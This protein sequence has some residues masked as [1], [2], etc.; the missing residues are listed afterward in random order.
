MNSSQGSVLGRKIRNTW[1]KGPEDWIRSQDP[2]V[3]PRIPWNSLSSG[4]TASLV[5]RKVGNQECA[6][7]TIKVKNKL[8]WTKLLSRGEEAA[9]AATVSASW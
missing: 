4:V 3:T 1:T 5:I 9:A 8:K 2:G 7:R 6:T